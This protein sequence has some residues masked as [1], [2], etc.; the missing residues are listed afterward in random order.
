MRKKLILF[1]VVIML[2][3]LC[4]ALATKDYWDSNK[5][6]WTEIMKAAYTGDINEIEKLI[7][8]GKDVNERIQGEREIVFTALD[9][10]IM[11]QNY[12]VV[13]ILLKEGAKVDIQDSTVDSPLHL[14][15][16][17][18]EA[19]IV[20]ILLKYG[21]DINS[22]NS[23]WTPLK[24]AAGHGSLEVLQ[25][26]I[27]NGACIENQN[28]DEGDTALM[29]AVYNGFLDKVSALLNAGANPLFE[30]S[31]G[32]TAYLLNEKQ[33]KWD[34][35]EKREDMIIQ[36]EKIRKLL[37]EAENH[38]KKEKAQNVESESVHK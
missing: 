35:G 15:S 13:E 11:V 31:K 9:V 16:A 14:A 18:N 4:K 6:T 24:F 32:E 33:I 22:K 8:S 1:T 36:R 30:N 19:D 5:E 34:I 7:K 2:I 37:I 29:L 10:A 38:W 3:F 21:A 26:L 28:T 20:D 27:N 12:Q 23:G 25:T 17:L